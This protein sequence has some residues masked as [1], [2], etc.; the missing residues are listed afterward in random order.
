MR[1]SVTGPSNITGISG[2]DDGERPARARPQRNPRQ[3]FIS[4]AHQDTDF[5]HRLAADL[6]QDGW[7]VW[8]APDSIRPGEKWVEAIN[9]GLAESSVFVVALTPAAVDSRWVAHE[10]DAAIMLTNRG[11][12]RFIPAEVAS[13]DAP[14]LWEAFH[15]IS[16][17]GRYADGL[18][19]LRA[20]LA[21]TA[22]VPPETT[23]H[24]PPAVFT[25]TSPIRLELVCI[26]AGEFLMG[27]DPA[28]D[29]DAQSGE[30]PQHR[31]TLPDFYI[32]KVPVTNA[33]FEVFVQAA[34]Y[35]TTSRAVRVPVGIWAPV[36]GSG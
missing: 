34:G 25:L 8:I 2:A 29:H 6:Q 14:P 10:A 23:H 35:R 4:H 15:W 16:F 13:C 28:V 36:N 26:P 21:Q 18:A 3:V 11:K 24:G 17:T 27:S 33:Q 1:W 31:V 9:R 30:Q 32:G 7:Q 19:V 5:A 12:M 22:A 20:T